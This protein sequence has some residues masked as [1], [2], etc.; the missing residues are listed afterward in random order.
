MQCTKGVD[1][2]SSST[3]SSLALF[4]PCKTADKVGTGESMQGNNNNNDSNN[5][6]RHG[7][8]SLFHSLALQHAVISSLH[9]SV[10]SKRVLVRESARVRVRGWMCF[11]FVSMWRCK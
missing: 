1:M 11:V 9:D 8:A 5:N 4:Y 3:F 2:R 6:N 10:N 7:L